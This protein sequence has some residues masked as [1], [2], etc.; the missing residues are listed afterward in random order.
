MLI[1]GFIASVPVVAYA[2]DISLDGLVG[3]W[4]ATSPVANDSNSDAIPAGLEAEILTLYATQGGGQLSLRVDALSPDP[5]PVEFLVQADSMSFSNGL[6]TAVWVLVAPEWLETDEVS[7]SI[8]ITGVNDGFHEH[9]SQEVLV[10]ETM[11][12]AEDAGQALVSVDWTTD[13][14]V[15]HSPETYTVCLQAFYNGLP[16]GAANCTTFGPF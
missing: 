3:D 8:E 6:T 12:L 2:L 11:F 10:S 14:N 5:G 4:E 7:L 15:T 13:P 1:L 9:G 16:F